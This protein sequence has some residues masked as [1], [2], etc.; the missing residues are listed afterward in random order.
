[1][2]DAASKSIPLV[3][4]I[5]AVF[6]GEEHLEST[7]LSILEQSY[8]NIELI[9]IDGGSTDG[10]VSILKK[11]DEKID[12]WVSEKDRGIGDAFNKGVEQAKG[13]YIN[14]QGDG[15]GFYGFDALDKLMQGVNPKKD[16]LISGRIQRIGP[17]GDLLYISPYVSNFKKSS[18]LF[19]MSMPHQGLF[20]HREYFN[21]HGD[22]DVNNTF[23]MDYEHLLRAYSD[24][25]RVVTKDVIV[26]RWRADGVGEN[27]ELEIFKE[28]NKIKIDN[29]V[30]GGLVLKAINLWVV[31][32][33]YI[34]TA[35]K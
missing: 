34:R 6:N 19:R 20:T 7:I 14:F 28:Y 3:S 15:D 32:K 10:T 24:F 27:R 21:K 5:I 18:L 35:V 17:N 13:C 31:L 9:V 16:I 12:Y 2:I 11:Y 8:K 29:Q 30:A 25:P 1:M 4:V 23:C 22:F 26:A 33:Y